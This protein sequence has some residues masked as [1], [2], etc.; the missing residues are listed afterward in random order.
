MGNLRSQCRIGEIESRQT[1]IDNPLPDAG[2]RAIIRILQPV[3]K[4]G[5]PSENWHRNSPLVIK[6]DIDFDYQDTGCPIYS[7]T[8]N[9]AHNSPV[10]PQGSAHL[11]PSSHPILL[12]AM[13]KR[14]ACSKL[15]HHKALQNDTGPVRRCQVNNQ[16]GEKMQDVCH[17]FWVGQTNH[18]NKGNGGYAKVIK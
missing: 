16:V 4:V 1:A 14:E 9:K 6:N 17:R 8:W 2:N 3:L 7:I 12:K 10:R 11:T 18:Q 15:C 5:V 13:K